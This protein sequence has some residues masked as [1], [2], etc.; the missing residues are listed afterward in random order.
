MKNVL[1]GLLCAVGAFG[2]VSCVNPQ[3]GFMNSETKSAYDY[4]AERLTLT[5][6]GV[7]FD[8]L[9][10]KSMAETQHVEMEPSDQLII[11]GVF[12]FPNEAAHEDA[13]TNKNGIQKGR[14]YTYDISESWLAKV[15]SAIH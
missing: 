5:V 7:V 4:G 6:D 10:L 14:R 3:V 1:L 9:H 13:F 15:E 8:C 12:S 2:I 11:E